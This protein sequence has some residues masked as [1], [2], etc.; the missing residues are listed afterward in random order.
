MQV[1]QVKV[2]RRDL[3]I[4]SLT[5]LVAATVLPSVAE[6]VIITNPTVRQHGP[7]ALIGDSLSA[8]NIRELRKMLVDHG[9]GPFRLDI[10]SGSSITKSWGKRK[11][12]LVRVAKMRE[13]GFDPGAWVI[14]LGGNDLADFRWKRRDPLTEINKML[15]LLGPDAVVAWPTIARQFKRWW[16]VAQQFN[17][18]LRV[19]AETHPNLHIIE[20]ADLLNQHNPKWYVKG[21][22]AHLRGAGVVAR[23]QMT[24]DA[25][26]LVAD[27]KH[28]GTV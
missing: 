5:G 24:T 15:D 18:A 11:S 6:A 8:G 17:D 4:G 16:P 12:G 13:S 14:A 2:T 1:S 25:M 21:D 27:A 20:W 22:N 7:V 19:A 9:V 3:L 28:G 26:I 10:V 23:N